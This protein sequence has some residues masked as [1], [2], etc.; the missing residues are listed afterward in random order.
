MI[1]VYR[2]GCTT[3]EPVVADRNWLLPADTVWL[4]LV[5]PTPE[6]D[7]AVEKALGLSVPTRAEM[8]SIEASSRARAASARARAAAT[9]ALVLIRSL[10]TRAPAAARPASRAARRPG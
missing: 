9:A 6:E 2:R 5:E 7:A 1:R 3:C 4:D 8:A 10:R